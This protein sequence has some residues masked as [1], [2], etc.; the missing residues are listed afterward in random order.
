MREL[1]QKKSINERKKNALLAPPTLL[2]KTVAA[3]ISSI[4][5]YTHTSHLT[6]LTQLYNQNQRYAKNRPLFFLTPKLHYSLNL[7]SMKYS[8]PSNILL[9]TVLD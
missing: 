8:F 7:F 4:K 1:Y 9:Y 2:K 5:P 3:A 6:C